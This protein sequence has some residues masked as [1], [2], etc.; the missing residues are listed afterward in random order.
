MRVTQRAINPYTIMLKSMLEKLHHL[1]SMF[2]DKVRI[3]RNKGTF[4]KGITPNWTAEVFT[5]G[6]VKATKPPTYTIEDTLGEWRTSS[7]DL[8]RARAA[9]ECTGN[10]S[11]RANTQEEEKW[12]GYSDAFNSWVP[13]ADLEV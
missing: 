3:T 7:R 4:E 12:K 2:G 9:I 8:L 13:L 6:S 11:Y 1:N 5:I 10:I